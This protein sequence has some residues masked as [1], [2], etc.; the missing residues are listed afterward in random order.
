MLTLRLHVA[1]WADCF[2]KLLAFNATQYTRVL[3]LDSDSLLLQPMDEL[4]LIPP[5]PVAMPRAYWLYPRKKMLSSQV[6][7]LQPDAVEFTLIMDKINTAEGSNYDMEIVNDLYM[8]SAMILPHRADD[9]LTS[10]WRHNNSNHAGYLGS[11]LEAWDAVAAYNEAKFVH[12]SDWPMPKPWLPAPESIRKEKEP[13][14]QIQDGVENC[15][16]RDIWN[17][18]YADFRHRRKVG[19]YLGNDLPSLGTSLY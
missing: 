7:L 18:F 15:A 1:T 11:D 5:C 12:F 3:S 9:V 4:F 19:V 17:G 8:D 16:D 6:M 10:E 13:P 14:C 2:T